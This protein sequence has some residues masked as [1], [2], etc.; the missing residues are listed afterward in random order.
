NDPPTPSD[1]TVAIGA[2][3]TAYT[4]A[5]GRPTPEFL[6]LGAGA[7]GGLTLAP[8]LYT[9]ASTVTIP[10]DVTVSGAPNDVWIFQVSGDLMMSADTHVTL[11]GGARSKNIF[12]QVAGSVDIGTASHVEGI[13]LSQTAINLGTGS[14]INGRLLAQT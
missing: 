14:S 8:G 11:E 1:L 12:W 3:E 5:A 4:D 2:M 7:I 9:W 10:T 6:D 13:I